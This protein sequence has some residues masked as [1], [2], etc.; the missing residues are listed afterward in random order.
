ML[1]NGG[2]SF[3]GVISFIFAD[4]I[5]IPILLIYRK[6]YG[7]RMALRMFVLFYATMVAAGYIIE[8][9][10]APSGLIP[11]TRNAKVITLTSR[12]T[13]TLTSTSSPLPSPLSWSYR[14]SVP[15]AGH[16][17][18]DGR[19]PRPSRTFCTPTVAL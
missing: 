7:T 15:A 18:R 13:A 5:I 19:P 16:G 8:L 17:R 4:L 1:W 12:S 11:S 3:G 2:I 6:Y 14:S 9:I 10:F